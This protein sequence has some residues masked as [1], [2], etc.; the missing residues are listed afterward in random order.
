MVAISAG[1]AEPI[2][3]ALLDVRRAGHAV[4]LLAIGDQR[5]VDVPDLIPVIWIG[6]HDAYTRSAEA[7]IQPW[8]ENR[9]WEQQPGQRVRDE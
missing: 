2:Y 3:T 9:L 8:S 5:P 7:G 6:G 4:M 1:P